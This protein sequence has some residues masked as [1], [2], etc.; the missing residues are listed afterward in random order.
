MAPR[1]QPGLQHVPLQLLTN[2]AS[3]VVL[4]CTSGRAFGHTH[5]TTRLCN[6]DCVFV[7]TAGRSAVC[8]M[9]LRSSNDAHKGILEAALVD[10]PHFPLRLLHHQPL[11]KAQAWKPWLAD[12]LQVLR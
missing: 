9:S 8:P 7:R 3:V 2:A 1:R 5:C 11:T 6:L 10:G 4:P 12:R